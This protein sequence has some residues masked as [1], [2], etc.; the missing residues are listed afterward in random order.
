MARDKKLMKLRDKK[1]E[2]LYNFWRSKK[3]NGKQMYTH[4]AI[5]EKIAEKVFLAPKTIDNILSG[6]NKK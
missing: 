4:E 3:I 5:L 6:R 2:S 1:I